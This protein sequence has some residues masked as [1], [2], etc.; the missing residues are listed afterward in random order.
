VR[1]CKLTHW[2][3]QGHRGNEVVVTNAD[4]VKNPRLSNAHCLQEKYKR[5]ML[6]AGRSGKQGLG[7]SDSGVCA[8]AMR[9]PGLQAVLEG[10]LKMTCSFGINFKPFCTAT[11]ACAHACMHAHGP[12]AT[13]LHR[14]G[15][16]CCHC[17]IAYMLTTLLQRC[18]RC[19]LPWPRLPRVACTCRVA[20]LHSLSLQHHSL[21]HSVL[22][23]QR[24]AGL[25]RGPH[26]A[27]PCKATAA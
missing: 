18:C 9:K 6:V 19:C 10:K 27:S 8:C 14:P 11:A 7:V 23:G 22:P 12:C 4:V 1:G 3:S 25:D 26:T 15:P 5:I 24:R 16:A 2:Q 21:S 13:W 17:Y 20:R